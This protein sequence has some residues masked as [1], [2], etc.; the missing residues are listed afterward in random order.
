MPTLVTG[1]SG[2]V[3]AALIDHLSGLGHDVRAFGRS[4]DRVRDAGVP[5]AVPFFGGDGVERQRAGHG[6]RRR[7]LRRDGRAHP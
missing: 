3:G 7:D 5:A 6:V 2:Y 1:A 4:E